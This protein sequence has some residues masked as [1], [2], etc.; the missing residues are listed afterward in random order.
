MRRNLRTRLTSSFLVA[1][2]ATA[3]LVVLLANLITTSQFKGYVSDAGQQYAERLA[4]IFAD[5][6]T[7]VG[8]WDGAE[9][10]M[11]YLQDT[12]RKG[13]PGA[14]GPRNMMPRP[15]M[16]DPEGERLLLID[17]DGDIIADSRPEKPTPGNVASSLDKGAEIVVDGQQVGTILVYS[18][19]GRLTD[20]QERFLRQVNLLLIAAGVIA[21]LGVLVVGSL[22]ARRIVKPVR[23]LVNAAH[24]VA[25]GDLSQR[26][27]VTS[28][29]ELGEMAAAFNTMAAE[30]EHQ[31][32]L[33]RRAMADVAH[34]LRTPLSVLQVQ[35]E[36]IED[37]LTQP[38]PDIISGL[39]ADVAHLSRLVED[40][41]VLSLADA[42]DL[43]VESEPVEV[44]GLVRDVVERMQG[45]AR[46][47][48]VTLKP[49]LPDG[50]LHVMG[51]RQRLTQVLL[52]LLSNSLAHTPAGGLVSV[53]AEQIDYAVR[54]V[55]H[56]NGEG[57][58]PEDLPH[59]FERFYRADQ[60]RSRG[61]GGSGL[62]LSIAK[63]LVEA[64][65]GTITAASQLGA[66]STFTITLPCR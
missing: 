52:N 42:G 36:S 51:D 35:L 64:H 62:G 10:L 45:A 14:P 44:T 38:T 17:L 50:E 32:E 28:D 48:S 60:A 11:A 46:A 22:Q 54:V 49:Q 16:V 63:S 6:Y 12:N 58:A 24:R 34:E 55:V 13:P 2:A 29:D 21:I 39:Q 31:H 7:E 23:A 8:G 20:A 56:D 27:P 18:S 1:I 37:E 33:R 3:A 30:L 15:G 41:R 25:E 57:I 53:T 9:D 5:H 26:I 4:P 61:T 19:L 65:G 40:L 66:G 59:I 43:Q 47:V